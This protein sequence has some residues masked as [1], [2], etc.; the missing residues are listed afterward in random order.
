MAIQV[1]DRLPSGSL[2]EF[3]EVES[4][5]CPVGPTALQVAEIAAGK[6]IVLFGVPGAFTPTC[7]AKH[8]PGYLAHHDALTAKGVDEI[9]CLAVNDAFVMQAWGKAQGTAGKIRL[10]ADGSGSYTRALG[11][12]LDLGARGLG[13]RCQRFSALVKDG[14]ITRLHLEAP[15]KFEVSDAETMLRHL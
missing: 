10:L 11:L 5:G 12:G 7:S 9:W 1:G 6:T 13:L 15:G 8:L 4:A 3:N 2:M 14:V